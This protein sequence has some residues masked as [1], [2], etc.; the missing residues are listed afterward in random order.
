M[1]YTQLS[2][3][4][5]KI[6]LS[7]QIC[8]NYCVRSNDKNGRWVVVSRSGAATIETPAT[9]AVDTQPPPATAGTPAAARTQT[10]AG[11]QQQKEHQQQHV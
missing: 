6:S 2:K 5:P 7:F 10:T 8:F 3:V 1:T 11:H 4:F 9:A